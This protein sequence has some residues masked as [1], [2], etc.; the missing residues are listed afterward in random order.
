M[1]EG[2]EASEITD[3]NVKRAVEW[4]YLNPDWRLSVQTHK[5]IGVE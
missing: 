2:Y 5:M 4:L 1:G 3:D